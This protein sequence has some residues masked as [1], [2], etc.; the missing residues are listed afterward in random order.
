[1]LLLSATLT[2]TDTVSVLSVIKRKKFPKIHSIIFGEGLLN[3]SVAVILF[4]ITL[5]LH[6]LNEELNVL[7]IYG[8]LILIKKFLIVTIFS[9]LIGVIVSYLY[10]LTVF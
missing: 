1:M 8:F 3:D 5:N 7:D 6:N 4:K 9:I 2:A 10:L